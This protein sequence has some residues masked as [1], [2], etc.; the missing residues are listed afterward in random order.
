MTYKLHI[1]PPSVGH[2]TQG[3]LM[4]LGTPSSLSGDRI[5]WRAHHVT[6]TGV[7]GY[8]SGWG[9]SGSIKDGVATLTAGEGP[10]VAIHKAI[11]PIIQRIAGTKVTIKNSQTVVSAWI[12]EHRRTGIVMT[13][14]AIIG[15][16]LVGTHRVDFELFIPTLS[17]F[18]LLMA[19]SSAVALTPDGFNDSATIEVPEFGRGGDLPT[20]L[21]CGVPGQRGRVAV[22]LHPIGWVP[23]TPEER[24]A[25]MN[26]HAILRHGLPE[27][28][29]GDFC[30]LPVTKTWPGYRAET[31]SYSIEPRLS[32]DD[33]GADPSYGYSVASLLWGSDRPALESL[34]GICRAANAYL[35]RQDSWV[36]AGTGEALYAA[37]SRASLYHADGFPLIPS[38]NDPYD[39]L[40]FGVARGTRWPTTQSGRKPAD[41]EHETGAALAAAAV[42]TNDLGY[43]LAARDKCRVLTYHYNFKSASEGQLDYTPSGRGSGRPLALLSILGTVDED[44]KAVAAD[45][46]QRW[47]KII[48]DAMNRRGVPR[49][50]PVHY[51]GL[52]EGQIAGYEE[53]TV[54]M[55]AL[56]CFRQTGSRTALEVAYRSGRTC[57]TTM[58]AI[59]GK[60]KAAYWF[61]PNADGSPRTLEHGGVTFAGVDMQSWSAQG[62]NV[63][64]AA[65]WRMA[66]LRVPLEHDDMLWIQV[67]I[68]A[69]E[70]LL[71]HMPERPSE[72]NAAYNQHLGRVD[73]IALSTP[74]VEVLP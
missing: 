67:A 64:L 57:A 13:S 1:S 25:Q 60:W 15:T 21:F 23:E 36:S 43:R 30:G 19:T 72:V 14:H 11:A 39:D 46:T 34:I 6:P 49:A 47:C 70:P 63:F 20:K 65:C 12:T 28:W 10:A 41:K 29:T 53:A 9:E 38:R 16:Q 74:T 68:Q 48:L 40:G 71:A 61:V 27:T 58:H 7:F 59:E 2:F 55:G 50:M 66:F 24:L 56:L 18:A 32:P 54:A 5:W 22:V 45:A 35:D 42:L 52:N 44:S 73:L 33:P 69:R 31:L 26:A 62:L 37:P 51:V 4:P 8:V 3:V 17:P